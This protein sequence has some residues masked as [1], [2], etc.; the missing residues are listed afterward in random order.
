MET[1]NSV[2]SQT[3]NFVYL[4]AKTIFKKE[5]EAQQLMKEV[6]ANALKEEVSG[7]R[8][9]PWLGKQ[10]YSLGCGKFRKKKVSEAVCIDL[11][12]DDFRVSESMNVELTRKV[13][14]EL[15][16]E[17]P[18]MYQATLYAIYYDQLKIKEVASLMGYGV[19]VILYR[20]NYCHKYIKR[21]LQIYAEDHNAKVA[22]SVE[23]LRMAMEDWSRAN[24]MDKTA[25]F[26]LLGSICR[27]I[28]IALEATCEEDEIAGAERHIMQYEERSLAVLCDEFLDYQPKEKKPFPT[29]I[30][31]G[32]VGGL[33]AAAIIAVAVVFCLGLKDKKEET[34]TPNP[35]IEN[36]EDESEELNNQELV[37]DT[38]DESEY[39]LPNSDTV[40]YTRE[41][42]QELTLEELRIARNELFARYGTYFGVADLDEYFKTKSWYTAKMSVAEF[43]DQIEMNEIELANLNLIRQIEEEKAQ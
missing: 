32:I 26:N 12:A 19:K 39:I 36:V 16:E 43:Y 9:F 31:L 38:V 1:L 10:V 13:I 24:V 8:Q 5:E 34:P 29:K 7:E 2:Y 37:E 17:L 33:L 30:V 28:G 18:D 35:V 11:D 42:L 22:F 41:Q 6:Y 25:A 21:A 40:K 14:C 3:Y 15:I 20:L 4:R 23:V 27:E